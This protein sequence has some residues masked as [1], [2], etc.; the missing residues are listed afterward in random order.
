MYKNISINTTPPAIEFLLTYGARVVNYLTT[1][2][3]PGKQA[4]RQ[5]FTDGWLASAVIATHIKRS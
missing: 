5:G 4:G 3:N 2:V 1:R